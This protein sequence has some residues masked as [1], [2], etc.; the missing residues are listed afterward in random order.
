MSDDDEVIIV[1]SRE[2]SHSR[3]SLSSLL[4]LYALKRVFGISSFRG[5]QEDVVKAALDERDVDIFVVMPTGGGKS[6]CFAL[7]AILR[8]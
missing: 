8:D 5:V 6:L 3:A 2:E 4:P 7:P 1:E